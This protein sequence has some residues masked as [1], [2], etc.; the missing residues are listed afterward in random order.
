MRTRS[1]A[2]IN[3]GKCL[4]DGAQTITIFSD[5]KNVRRLIARDGLAADWQKLGE[6]FRV[7]LAAEKT[8]R[9]REAG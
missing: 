9:E 4:L 8:R 7:A 5:M 1:A 6:D 3:S 2:R